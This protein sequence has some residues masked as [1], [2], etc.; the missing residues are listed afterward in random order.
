MRSEA[1]WRPPVLPVE[2]AE[3]TNA[4]IRGLG[5]RGTIWGGPNDKDYDIWESICGSPYFGKVPTRE[6]HKDRLV[7]SLA[8]FHARFGYI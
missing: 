6:A 1:L 8:G 4:G 2:W 3:E 7:E 5:F